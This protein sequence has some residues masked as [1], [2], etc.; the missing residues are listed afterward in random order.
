M[1]STTGWSGVRHELGRRR[2][3]KAALIRKSQGKGQGGIEYSHVLAVKTPD[4]PSDPFTS[5][6]NWLVSHDLRPAPQSI[7]RAGIDGD[8]KIRSIGQL[9]GQLTDNDRGVALRQGVRL[10]DDGWPGLAIVAGRGNGDDIT[11]LHR[12]RIRR[13]L[14]SMSGRPARDLDRARLP[15]SPRA[16]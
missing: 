16:V 3:W 8:S 2:R 9:R 6:R 11:A 14:R 13:P 4:L 1:A 15:A 7:F 10:H 12:H 5:D